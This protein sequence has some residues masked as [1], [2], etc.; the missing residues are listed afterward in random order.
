MTLGPYDGASPAPTPRVVRVRRPLHVERVLRWARG[1]CPAGAAVVVV[2]AVM[3]QSQ[4]SAHQTVT[5]R[6]GA[7]RAGEAAEPA[8]EAQGAG[9]SWRGS[10]GQRGPGPGLGRG[11]AWGLG[12]G[13]SPA[14][15]SGCWRVAGG[16]GCVA[17]ARVD[18]ECG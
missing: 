4:W 16:A 14:A 9:E 10:C 1:R 7:A 5:R 8:G 17:S 15:L 12:V 13:G 6:A 3:K 11:P 2:T 18:G